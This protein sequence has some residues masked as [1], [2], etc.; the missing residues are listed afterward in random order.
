MANKYLLAYLNLVEL[1][2][3]ATEINTDRHTAL[4]KFSLNGLLVIEM[5]QPWQQR[6]MLVTFAM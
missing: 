6:H 3:K 1:S 2:T 4:Q 5:L